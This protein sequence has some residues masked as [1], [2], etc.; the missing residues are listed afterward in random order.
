MASR[1]RKGKLVDNSLDSCELAGI[2]P[3]ITICVAGDE[4]TVTDNGSG[5]PADVIGRILD[6]STRTSDKAAYVSP[7]RDAQGNALKTV[8]AIPYVLNGG[9][10]PATVVIESLGVRHV[11]TV[12]TDHLARRPKI[13]RRTISIVKTLG[14]SIRLALDSACCEGHRED[15]RFLQKLVAGYALFNP[16]ST[17]RLRQDGEEQSW[18]ATTADWRKW[19][20]AD[21]TSAH[22]YN[23]ERIENLIASYVAAEG[24]GARPRTVREFISEFRGLS[25]SAKQKEVSAEAGL[26]RASLHN[27]VLPDRQLDHGA[28]EKLLAAI[29]RASSPVKPEAL[30]ILGEPHFRQR[31]GGGSTF[32]YKRIAGLTHDSLPFVVEASFSMA[33]RPDCTSHIGLNWS[34]P[35]SNPLQKTLLNSGEGSYVRGLESLLSLKRIAL[36]S[37]PVCMARCI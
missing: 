37:D 11:V 4:L 1:D 29:K 7:T 16:H 10:A 23:Q 21:P 28:V 36:E 8:L 27:L 18:A 3:E 20:P 30:G 33:D 13:E 14:T 15:P 34:V 31:L 24:D 5:L 2:A 19:T 35:I 22:W 17:F 32:I 9:T 12:S 6:F 26:E 25:G